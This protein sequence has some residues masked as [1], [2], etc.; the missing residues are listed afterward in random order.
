[1]K[2]FEIRNAKNSDVNELINLCKQLG[3]AIRKIDLLEQLSIMVKSDD[4]NVFVCRSGEKVIGWLHVQVSRRIESGAFAEIG[5]LVVDKDYAKR[6]IGKRLIE[7]AENWASSKELS[8]IRV[9]CN[10]RRSGALKFYKSVGFTEK[11]T[12]KILDK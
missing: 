1:M 4:H 3:Y 11:K 5:G 9:R 12:Q 10:A 6:G 2:P 7:E 8:T